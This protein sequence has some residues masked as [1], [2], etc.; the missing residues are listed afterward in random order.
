MRRFIFFIL[1]LFPAVL[2][3]QTTD[4]RIPTT[5]GNAELL[6]NQAPVFYLDRTNHTSTQTQ[7]TIDDLQDSL[8]IKVDTTD[9]RLTDSRIPTGSAG[10]ELGGTYP[11]P[12]VDT[13]NG[14][15]NVSQVIGAISTISV[16]D[17]LKAGITDSLLIS[18][19]AFVVR[20]TGQIGIG[21]ASPNASSLLEMAST[22]KGFL[23]PRMTSTQRD[24]ISS[25]AAGLGIY[26]TTDNIPNFYNGT[27]WRRF[28]HTSAASLSADCIIFAEGTSALTG[29]PNFVWDNGGKR[30]GIGTSSPDASAILDVSDTTRGLLI[31]RM[32]ESQRDAI[33]SPAEGLIVYDSI[34][35]KLNVYNGS[36]WRGIITAP[37]NTLIPGGIVLATES[38]GIDDDPNE[39][40]WDIITHSLGI[41]TNIPDEALE[42]VG[43]VR[44]DR[45]I[46]DRP[47]AVQS[48]YIQRSSV[49][50]EKGIGFYTVDTERMIIREGGKVG[51]GTSL[52]NSRLQI[53]SG[54]IY[55]ETQGN[56]V[57]LR[58]TDG[59][60]CHRITVNTAG[61]ITATVVTCP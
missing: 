37:A 44:A 34:D 47:G 30:A 3:S 40:H 14:D 15:I 12:T 1:V 18:T 60:G 2:F 22:V 11:N 4:L 48:S 49:G 52:P 7:S 19:N 27:A 13:L 26:S 38:H 50:V 8:D 23:L 31:P 32:T 28:T 5:I 20:T 24:N 56:G 39:I 17:S 33:A 53:T 36:A 61:T 43:N 9:G 45:F 29:N 51:I 41:R 58:D 55:I 10:G 46:M 57:I 6:N 25:P 21:T 16:S 42:V 54:D 35:H 59:A